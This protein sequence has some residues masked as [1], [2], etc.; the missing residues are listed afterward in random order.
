MI[1]SETEAFEDATKEKRREL[2][3]NALSSEKR[4][5]LEGAS[6]HYVE[7]RGC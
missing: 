3:R 2:R 1:L 6:Y 5:P 7:L 4:P